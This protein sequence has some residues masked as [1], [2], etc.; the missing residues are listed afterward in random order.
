MT[1]MLEL[2]M[3]KAIY[4]AHKNVF[5]ALI[6]DCP[7]KPSVGLLKRQMKNDKELINNG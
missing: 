3:Y 4:Y 5:E 6:D 7:H 1:E 2:Q